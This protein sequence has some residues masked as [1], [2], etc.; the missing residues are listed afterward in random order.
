MVIFDDNAIH[1]LKISLNS[2]KLIVIM[3]FNSQM[4]F[5]Q[6]DTKKEFCR[7]KRKRRFLA[8]CGQI[9]SWVALDCQWG[10]RYFIVVYILR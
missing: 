8:I 5:F 7:K 1:N 4:P 2:I 10:C 6:Q 3:L 9:F